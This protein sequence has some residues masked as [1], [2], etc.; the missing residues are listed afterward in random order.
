[1]FPALLCIGW[2][3]AQFAVVP[4][5]NDSGSIPPANS[6]SVNWS[7]IVVDAQT[8]K[9]LACRVYLQSESGTWHFVESLDPQGEARPY[10]EQ[11]VP[12]PQSVEQHTTVS[13]H[14][15][16]VELPPGTYRITIERG[17]EFVPLQIDE[18]VTAERQTMR[19]YRL[20][21]WVDMGKRGWY[22]GET[23]VH[24]RLEELPNVMLAEDLN[25]AFPVTFWT[26]QAAT[27]PG[28]EPSPL[29]RQG[30]SPFGPRRDAG[31]RMLKVDTRHVI[32]PRNTEYEIFS[33]GTRRHVLGAV[34]ILNHQQPFEVGMPPVAPI[35]REAHR[36]GALLDLDKHS[37]PWA[38]MLVPVA[39]IDL[40]ELSNNS[41]WRT[42]FG[43]RGVS[44][45]LPEYADIE[46]EAEGLTEW[47]WLNFGWENYYALLNCGFRLAPT[48]GTA[49]GVH[50]VPLGYSRVYVHTGPVFDP[51]AWLDG[52]RQGRS[53]VTTGPMIDV[54][55][56]GQ[57][58]G[59]RFQV[60]QDPTQL[61]LTGQILSNTNLDRIEIL[62]NGLVV[63]EVPLKSAAPRSS[64]GF[65]WEL[66]ES[67]QVSEPSWLAVRCYHRRGGKVQFA[68]TAPWYIDMP[69]RR[70]LPR[71]EQIQYLIRRVAQELDRNREILSKEALSEFQQALSFYRNVQA[72]LNSRP[73]SCER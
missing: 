11:W 24:R 52:L 53:F 6:Q 71:P 7:A 25:V 22:S 67:I 72:G 69:N 54:L 51:Q 18:T 44:V 61:R 31:S 14:A 36:Q 34:F 4:A 49:S 40:Y 58:A 63:R 30:P 19:T 32:F 42:Q 5:A 60:D 65:Q 33:V 20:R 50:P 29:R 47:G 17:K 56:A 2:T 64:A 28:L 27:I 15:F 12:M 23:H 46:Q 37:W 45:E 57:R 55:L 13:A 39:K 21:R 3:W 48:A 66:D 43:F 1:M 16:G 41:V 38:M 9:P 8:G 26:T 73:E 70:I 35:A 10:R 62:R 68:H 59:H